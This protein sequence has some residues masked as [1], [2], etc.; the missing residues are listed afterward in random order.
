MKLKQKTRTTFGFITTANATINILRL[1]FGYRIELTTKKLGINAI[2]LLSLR[3][4]KKCYA[5][6]PQ[7]II[8]LKGEVH[9]EI[10]I[11]HDTIEKLNASNGL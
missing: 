5:N 11:I 7:T 1:I 10:K 6:N 3:S 8:D 2:G 9:A 4:G